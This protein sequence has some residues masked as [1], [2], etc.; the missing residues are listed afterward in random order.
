MLQE[1]KQQ[2]SS[3]ASGA[4]AHYY[5]KCCLD[6]L[7]SVRPI[8]H[9]TI[10]WWPTECPSYKKWYKMLYPHQRLDDDTKFQILCA[11]YLKLNTIA[12]SGNCSFPNAL[13]QTCWDLKEKDGRLAL[14]CWTRGA[15]GNNRT[16]CILSWVAMVHRAPHLWYLRIHNWHRRAGQWKRKMDMA[17]TWAECISVGR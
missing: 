14:T 11:I 12:T 15:W 2:A 6:R 13:A 7:F 8:C 4:F 3:R 10:S 17:L 9:G 16:D 1:W 5:M